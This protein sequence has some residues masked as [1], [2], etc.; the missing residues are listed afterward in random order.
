MAKKKPIL[1]PS[2]KGED[3]FKKNLAFVN[4]NKQENDVVVAGYITECKCNTIYKN[5]IDAHNC[6]Y[7][8]NKGMLET[9]EKRQIRKERKK[10]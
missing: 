6:R 1:E 10:K 3:M 9:L 5:E 4:K 2:E 7:G 8:M